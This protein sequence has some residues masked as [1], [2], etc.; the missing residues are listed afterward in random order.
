M[1][2]Q[3]KT[4]SNQELK[5]PRFRNLNLRLRRELDAFH[6]EEHGSSGSVD[7]IMIIFVA[8]IILIGLVAMFNDTIWTQVT[9][10]V[11]DL[12]GSAIG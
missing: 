2:R 6:D 3:I 5:A 11:E 4:E 12:L 7:N 1:L 10:T 8:A 9:T